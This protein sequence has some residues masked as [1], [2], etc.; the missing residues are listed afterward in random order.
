[1]SLTLN[2]ISPAK[3]SKKKAKRVGR[4]IERIQRPKS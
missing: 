2:T 1:M 3:N 4:G